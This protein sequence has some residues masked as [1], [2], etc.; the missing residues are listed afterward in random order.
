MAVVES[1]AV[2]DRRPGFS[3]P[4]RVMAAGLLAAGAAFASALPVWMR[5]EVSTVL[6]T[7]TLDISGADA[8]PAVTALALVAVA[9]A[10]AVRIAGPLVR[11]L[12]AALVALAGVGIVVNALGVVADPQGAAVTEVSAATGTTAPANSYV[13]TVMPWLAVVAGVLVVLAGL[14]AF[15]VAPRWA[16]GRKYDRSAAR[17]ARLASAEE[18][19]D[20]DTW[21]S[22]SEGEDPT[23]R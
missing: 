11:R 2:T 1:R 18:P 12:V 14:W 17:A 7:S 9:G 20:I 22:L 5:A 8:A 6:E 3:T 4:G 21:D 23:D 15:V 16:V 10:V 19:D 13:L